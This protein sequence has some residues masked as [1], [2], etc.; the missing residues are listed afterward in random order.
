MKDRIIKELKTKLE[1][2]DNNLSEVTTGYLKDVQHMRELLF[3]KDQLKS[4]DIELYE[5]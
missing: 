1:V 5:V 2:R 3:R 4:G